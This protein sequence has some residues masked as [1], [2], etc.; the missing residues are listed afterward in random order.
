MILSSPL[1]GAKMHRRDLDCSLHESE[2]VN[3]KVC[4]RHIH[5]GEKKSEF[6]NVLPCT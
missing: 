5:G 4:S 3:E 6:S 2:G 1:N